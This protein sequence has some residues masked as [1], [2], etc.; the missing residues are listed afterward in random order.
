MITR[1]RRGRGRR[2]SL[3]AEAGMSAVMLMIAMS[4]V[5]R[6]VGW[7]AAERRDL[8]HR[9]WAVQEA[10]NLMERLTSRSFD[11]LTNEGV[12]DLTLSP[13]AARLLRD[14]ELRVEVVDHDPT[15]G[16]DSKRIALTLRWRG[17]SGEW[18]GP[19]RLTSWVYRRKGG[20]R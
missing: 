9:Q 8:D 10:A 1:G 2:G 14:A 16:E 15:G 13:E 3:L 7:T 11:S 6:V 5:A 4:L 12:K 19:V 17:R 20:P 18:T